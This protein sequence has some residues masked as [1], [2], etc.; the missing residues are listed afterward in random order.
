MVFEQL[1]RDSPE[2][3][4]RCAFVKIQF[5]ALNLPPTSPEEID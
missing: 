5:S 4:V 2:V 1:A 3:W